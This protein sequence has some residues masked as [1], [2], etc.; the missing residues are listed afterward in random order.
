MKTIL[1]YGDSNTFGFNPLDGSQYDEEARW[2]GILSENLSSIAKVIVDGLNNRTGFV[3][4]P[5]GF[6]YSTQR[7]FPKFLSKL[8]DSV[9]LI[10]LSVGTN[11]LQFKYDIK[12]SAVERGLENLINITQNKTD[13][14]I[15][16][17]PVILS[18]NILNGYF[19]KQ[20][21]ETSIIKSKKVGK[22]Y[23]KLAKVYNCKLFD[24]NDFASPSEADGLHY[25]RAAH[26]L[27]AEKLTEF[28]KTLINKGEI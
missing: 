14:V 10:I 7:H 13:N 5:D 4:N 26:K 21:D 6:L 23:K 20:F 27:I 9:D 17:P 11:D 28:I 22:A 3:N 24:I 1:C 16:I 12:F 8:E 25:D 2:S 19:S 18:D 15:L